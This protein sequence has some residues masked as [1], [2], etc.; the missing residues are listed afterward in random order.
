MRLADFRIAGGEGERICEFIKLNFAR[1][2]KRGM[3]I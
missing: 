1:K 3:L 2:A